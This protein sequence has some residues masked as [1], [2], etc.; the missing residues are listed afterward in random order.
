MYYISNVDN[1]N[2]GL[3]IDKWIL[4]F[5]AIFWLEIYFG[6]S[7]INAPSDQQINDFID[8]K[9]ENITLDGFLYQKGLAGLGCAILKSNLK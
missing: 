3:Y 5:G 4:Y 9:Q 8:L 6:L 2:M 7:S 1:S